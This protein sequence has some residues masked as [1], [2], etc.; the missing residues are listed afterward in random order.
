VVFPALLFMKTQSGRETIPRVLSRLIDHCV[1]RRNFIPSF[2]VLDG[3]A[4]CF[5]GYIDLPGNPGL[6]GGRFIL[7]N[8]WGT[9]WGI[10]SPYGAGYGTLPYRYIARF[11]AEAY[12]IA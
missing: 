7:R 8:S 6:G 11:G 2:V 9:S 4:M 5:V 10:N 12:S 1:L 3:H